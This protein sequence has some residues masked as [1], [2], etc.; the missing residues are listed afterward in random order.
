MSS[1]ETQAEQ[2]TP[3]MPSLAERPKPIIHYLRDGRRIIKLD[4]A[5]KPTEV[6][7][8][9]QLP[10]LSQAKRYNRE[11]LEGKATKGTWKIPGELPIIEQSFHRERA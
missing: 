7:E 10:S 6:L 1:S 8:V 4:V 5:V 3:A 11:M 9:R 2:A